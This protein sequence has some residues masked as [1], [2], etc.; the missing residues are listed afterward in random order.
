MKV[1]TKFKNDR[2]LL[3]FCAMWPKGSKSLKI[4]VI[5]AAMKTFQKTVFFDPTR[6]KD[7]HMIN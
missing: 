6:F 3:E 1:K 5:D 7:V 2:C 4:F